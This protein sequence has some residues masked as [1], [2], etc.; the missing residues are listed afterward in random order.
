MSFFSSDDPAPEVVELHPLNKLRSPST[1]TYPPPPASTTSDTV[2]HDDCHPSAITHTY[3]PQPA[4]S[5]SEECV[6]DLDN[7]WQSVHRTRDD[8]EQRVGNIQFASLCQLMNA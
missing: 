3:P 2:D 6:M 1:H 4:I 8:D 5:S 7:P